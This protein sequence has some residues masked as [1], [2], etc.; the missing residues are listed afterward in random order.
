MQVQLGHALQN[1]FGSFFVEGSVGGV[2]KEIVHVDNEPSFS[3]H[4]VEGVVHEP[5]K[6]G[7]GV[8]EPEEHD[9]GFE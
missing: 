9:S 5:L 3:D 4:I 6:G 1:T 8:G 2:D 7:R